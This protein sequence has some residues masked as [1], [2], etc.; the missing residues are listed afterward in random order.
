MRLIF[1]FLVICLSLSDCRPFSTEQIVRSVVVQ[2]IFHPK[3]G[4]EGSLRGVGGG[5]GGDGGGGGV[6]SVFPYPEYAQGWYSPACRIYAA[7]CAVL[8][9]FLQNR[10]GCRDLASSP[11]LHCMHA[12]MPS[13]K[14]FTS[15]RTF[16]T[17]FLQ[18]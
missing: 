1:P 9:S 5:G 12:C 8:A 16:S 13:C 11:S 7:V 18:L 4:L 6:G 10:T 17:S 3:G 2:I 15:I 14:D